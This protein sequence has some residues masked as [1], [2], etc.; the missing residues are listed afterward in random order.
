[1]ARS[2]LNFAHLIG[3]GRAVPAT[4]ARSED[5]DD[6]K[7]KEARAKTE[8]DAG[9]DEDD[10]EKKKARVKAEEDDKKKEAR[11]RA[12]KDDEDDEKKAAAVALMSGDAADEADEADPKASAIRRRE[13]ARCAAIF[14]CAAAGMRPDVAAQLAFATNLTRS[15]AINTMVAV[16]A[17]EQRPAP[18]KPAPAVAAAPEPVVVG[19]RSRM[20]IEPL[21]DIGTDVAAAGEGNA[22]TLAAQILAAGKKRRGE[23]A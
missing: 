6:D 20:A 13:R 10:D 7:N 11:A 22:P 9:D 21:I 5:D 19:L 16:A 8:D 2:G 4:A 15:A 3:I 18:V 12:E 1:M 14:G 23:A 17:G